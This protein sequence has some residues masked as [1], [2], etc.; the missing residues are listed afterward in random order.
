MFIWVFFYLRVC[1]ISQNYD[2]NWTQTL[3]VGCYISN[4]NW[5]VK[6]WQKKD[7]LRESS[8]DCLQK[9]NY[10]FNFLNYGYESVI[11]AETTGKNATLFWG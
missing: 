9:E 11:Y 10:A 6:I 2:G 5:D 4:I 8:S 7:E 1:Q 3:Q